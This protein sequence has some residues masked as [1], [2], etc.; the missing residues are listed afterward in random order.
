LSIGFVPK[1]QRKKGV[2]SNTLEQVFLNEIKDLQRL[3]Q[4]SSDFQTGHG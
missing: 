3:F 4:C 1:Q 2:C